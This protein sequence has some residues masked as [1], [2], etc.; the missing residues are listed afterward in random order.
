[1]AGCPGCRACFFVPLWVIDTALYL[2]RSP[3][4]NSLALLSNHHDNPDIQSIWP[5]TCCLPGSYYWIAVFFIFGENTFAQ[6]FDSHSGFLFYGSG[7]LLSRRSR[8]CVGFFAHDNSLFAFSTSRL[9]AGNSDTTG[10][11]SYHLD[12]C[13]VCIFYVTQTGISGIDSI[14]PI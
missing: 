11:R 14:W 2:C 12:S 1:M 6:G 7:L 13:R 10:S 9:V 4:F 8:R 5:S 3:S